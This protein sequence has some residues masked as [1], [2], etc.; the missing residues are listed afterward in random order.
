[1][2]RQGKITEV[3]SD[4]LSSMHKGSQC[5][6]F[7][8]ESQKTINITAALGSIRPSRVLVLLRTSGSTSLLHHLSSI[9]AIWN[10]LLLLLWHQW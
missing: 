6:A 1:M 5:L 7:Q 4:W 3:K 9:E 2:R 8:P 10:E